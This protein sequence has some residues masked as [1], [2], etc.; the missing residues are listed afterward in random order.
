MAVLSLAREVLIPIT[1]AVL[2]SF[3]LASL[4]RL[5][6]RLR[7]PKVVAVLAAV[8]LGVAVLGAPAGLMGLQVSG[9]TSDL[10]RYVTTIENKVRSLS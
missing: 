2:L 7:F 8:V 4:V 3:L 9:L 1:L 6:Q 10:P 5:L